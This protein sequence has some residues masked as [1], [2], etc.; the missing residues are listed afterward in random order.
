M[1][2]YEGGCECGSVRYRM[3]D[4]PIF[5]NCCH[6]R[7]CQKITGSAFA[8]N[9]MIESDRLEL[10]EGG[11]KLARHEGEARCNECGTLLWGEHSR[12]GDTIKFVR[13]GTLDEGERIAPDAHFF[14]RSKHSWVAIP[15][16]IPQ[17]EMLPTDSDPPLLNAAAAARFNAARRP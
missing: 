12:F 3:G 11:D 13:L 10:T 5:V 15:D 8:I 9:G 2:H 4:K 16:G 14:V 1:A 17:F 7:Q 6:C